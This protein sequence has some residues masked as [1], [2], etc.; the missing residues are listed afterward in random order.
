MQPCD[1][2]PEPRLTIKVGMLGAWLSQQLDFCVAT[3]AVS[4]PHVECHITG[5]LLPPEPLDQ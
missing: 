2:P 1:R 5:H 3:C 4:G